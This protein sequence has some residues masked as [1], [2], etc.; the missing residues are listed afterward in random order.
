M[1]VADDLDHE[2]ALAGN[3]GA[4]RS[5]A[6]GEGV[7]RIGQAGEMLGGA[8]GVTE[9]HGAGLRVELFLDDLLELFGRAGQHRV[10][11]GIEPRL[12]RADFFAVRILDSFADDHDAIFVGIDCFFNFR[13]KLLLFERQL[14]QQDDVRRIGR[15]AALGKHRAGGDPTGRRGP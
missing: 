3:G 15:I 10:T 8:L 5:L 4:H 6:A 12:V 7:V 11:K 13:E 1:R 2:T 9:L 14:R